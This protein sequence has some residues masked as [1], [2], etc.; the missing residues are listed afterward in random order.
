HP[1]RRMKPIGARAWRARSADWPRA[2]PAARCWAPTRNGR[3]R[4]RTCCSSG[5]GR[6]PG[7]APRRNL[8]GL[9]GRLGIAVRTRLQMLVEGS[10]DGSPHHVG[11]DLGTAVARAGDLVKRDIAPRPLQRVVEELALMARDEGVLLAMHD[12]ERWRVLG[13]VFHG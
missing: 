4:R 8:L 9:C 11:V 3:P 5:P 12:E 1:C 6:A 10:L 13:D 2:E 7:I